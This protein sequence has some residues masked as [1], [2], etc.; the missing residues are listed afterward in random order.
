MKT[1]GV[2]ANENKPRAADVLKHIAE[3]AQ[4]LGMALLSDGP[5]ARLAE[6]IEAV[7]I[8]DML[9]RAEAIL[10]LGGDGT[11]LRAVRALEGRD[12]PLMGVN[13]GGLGFLTSTTEDDIDRA[14]ECLASGNVTLSRWAVAEAFVM[15]SGREV[16]H[17]RALN[18]IVIRSGSSRVV[19]LDVSVQNDPVTPYVCDG[20]IVS[21]PA[22]STGYSMSA[23][24]PILLP[25]TGAFVMSLICPHTLSSRPLVVPDKSDILVSVADTGG[26]LY[27]TADGQV[28][29]S[30][31]RGDCVRIQ[32]SDADVRF[33]H[34]PGHSYFSVL[35]QKLHWSGTALR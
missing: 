22:G 13:I 2:I 25:G 34:L 7:E 18:D 35:R 21:T 20:L 31:E 26:A 6:N 5:T 32:R 28:G 33:V 17:Y 8:F 16:G 29:Q 23:G 12:R 4:R 19:T 14:M 3:C 30:L 27:L 24:G 1:L 11:M 15:S 9:D 10:A